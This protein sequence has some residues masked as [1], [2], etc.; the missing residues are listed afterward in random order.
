MALL[1]N[2]I[3]I[4]SSVEMRMYPDCSRFLTKASFLIDKNEPW[5]IKIH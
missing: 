4:P 2:A 5:I 1:K 3:S